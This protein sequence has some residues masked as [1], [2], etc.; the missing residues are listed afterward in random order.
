MLFAPTEIKVFPSEDPRLDWVSK[1]DVR[2]LN[3]TVSAN[4]VPLT[5]EQLVPHAEGVALPQ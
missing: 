1:H 3:Y 4:M 2:S 5:P